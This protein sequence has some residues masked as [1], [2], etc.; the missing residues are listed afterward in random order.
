MNC[1]QNVPAM[2]SQTKVPSA[3]TSI[4]HFLHP[5]TTHS[6]LY[7]TSSSIHTFHRYS[8]SFVDR[9]IANF[10]RSHTAIVICSTLTLTPHVM[11]D[12]ERPDR[13]PSRSTSSSKSPSRSPNG[14]PRYDEPGFQEYSDNAVRNILD[15]QQR[16]REEQAAQEDEANA[17]AEG[18]EPAGSSTLD[19]S[20]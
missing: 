5:V 2:P 13:S 20:K 9:V 14:R 19:P 7:P 16:E 18:N 10:I 8:V 4:S 11:F 15:Q 3:R 17:Q 6:R 12:G 1:R